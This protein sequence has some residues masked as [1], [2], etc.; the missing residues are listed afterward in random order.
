MCKQTSGVFFLYVI[1]RIIIHKYYV[2]LHNIYIIK[3][4]WCIS[5]DS[6]VQSYAVF[7]YH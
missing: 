2:R 1:S 5:M 6:I 7:I 4:N 3:Y